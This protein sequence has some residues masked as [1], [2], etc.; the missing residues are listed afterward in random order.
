[1]IGAAMTVKS[2]HELS[3]LDMLNPEQR[4]A[5][6]TIDGPL[7]VLAG[8][9]T[10][11]TRVLT[12]R[13]CHILLTDRAYPSQV[14]AVTFTNKA[15]TEMKERIIKLL[16][17]PLDGLWL[18]TFHSL[19]VRILRRHG[20]MVG[21][22]RSF[23][24]LDSDD[25]I[26][27][28]K[29]LMPYYG[30]DDKKMPARVVASII[31]RWKDRALTP[32]TVPHTESSGKDTVLRLYADYEKR[33]LILNAVDFGGLL[34]QCLILFQKHPD[35]LD[36]YQN[37]FHYLLVDEYQ[38]TNVAQYLWLRLLAQKSKNICCVGDD[39]QSIYGWRGAE[40]ANILRFEEDFPGAK[41]I[42]LE[43]NYRSSSHIL[44]AAGALISKNIG[45]FGKTLWT[46][47]KTGE[48]VIARCTWDSGAEAHFIAN[49]IDSLRRQGRALTDIAVLV[50]ATFQ[51]REIEERLLTIGVPYRVVGGVR[52]YERLEIRDALAYFRFLVQPDDGMAFERIMNTPKRGLGT[53]TLQQ[54]HEHARANNISL[55][56]AALLLAQTSQ[57]KTGVCKKL[58]ALF[59]QFEKWRADLSHL[60]HVKVAQAV[61]EESGYIDMWRADKA[62]DSPGRVENLKE[63]LSALDS[64][65]T[66][67][68]FLEHVSLV[69]DI[70]SNTH[71]DMV[72]LM[73]LHAAKGLEFEVVYLSGWEEGV[74]PNS[75]AL[76]EN[77]RE[78]LEE[79]RR[80]AYVGL[81]R[82]RKQAVITYAMRRH[83]YHGYQDSAPSRFLK[84]LPEEHVVFVSANG[85]TLPGIR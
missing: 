53:G 45:R 33:L 77:G 42:R 51:T 25:Q 6:E 19:A 13:L 7:L 46:D 9:G 54:I 1:M 50:R 71:G 52:F 78:G 67:S 37:Q 18:G 76:E 73:T 28:I 60:N 55:P 36:A 83:M 4:D 69:M 64:F 66:L 11:K 82:A 20:D 80:L 21:L 65:E 26:R 34:L 2:F 79:E 5:V 16:N 75:R 41:I 8:A 22:D 31:N 14:L 72:T 57:L 68:L 59:E 47:Q 44:G 84:E 40:V 70:S 32:D 15:A 39:D 38:D 63:L 17:R 62:P 10:G 30:I 24:I 81:T 29:Q 49:H 74:F 48:K 58:L 12:T 35:I 3:Y 61:L 27:L 56:K 85:K 23:T 43:H